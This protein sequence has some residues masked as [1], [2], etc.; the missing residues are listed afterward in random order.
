MRVVE[1]RSHELYIRRLVV[2]ATS[3]GT[4]RANGRRHGAGASIGFLG[5]AGLRTRRVAN[6]ESSAQNDLGCSSAAG[7][8][9]AGRGDTRPPAV[10]VGGVLVI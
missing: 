8:Y 3:T 9:T 7:R 2:S 5:R 10:M 6:K 1:L 4:Q